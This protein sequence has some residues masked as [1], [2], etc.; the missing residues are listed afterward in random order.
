M[1]ADFTQENCQRV[2]DFFQR[3]V[4]GVMEDSLLRPTLVELRRLD[5]VNR[6]RRVQ[7][8]RNTRSGKITNI[9]PK[10]KSRSV[11]MLPLD[12]L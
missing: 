12:R 5:Q 11:K 8:E 9:K 1:R 10:G 4:G 3:I 6:Q 2:Q 7:F